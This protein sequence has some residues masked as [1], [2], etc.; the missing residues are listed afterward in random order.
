MSAKK[1]DVILVT[2]GQGFIGGYL[3]HVLDQNGFHNVISL[4]GFKKGLDLGDKD[5]IGWVFDE[6]KPDIVIHLACRHAGL[7][8]NL[9]NPAGIMYENINMTTGIMEEAC[10]NDCK[11][12]IFIGDILSYPE[13]C[14][15]PFKESD[16]WFGYPELARSGYALTKRFLTEMV[17]NYHLEGRIQTTSLIFPE[18]YGSNDLLDPRYGRI[19][20]T[21]ILNILHC[22]NNDIEEIEIE[23][24]PNTTR[25]LLY[26]ADAARAILLAVES[27]S[28][29]DIINIGS[30][31]ETSLESLLHMVQNY[32]DTNIKINWKQ[33]KMPEDKRRLL[34]TS[35]SKSILG[36]SPLCSVESG[37]KD[38][39]KWLSGR[40]TEFKEL[41]SL[42]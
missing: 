14:P 7:P 30:G 12:F 15:I 24:N 21:S 33:K 20:P 2:G 11:K 39:C 26:V 32:L 3:K 27:E 8:F 22:K 1:E 41:S 10:W 31:V 6:Y 16:L 34:D 5:N 4:P 40:E 28:D 29:G 13:N 35:K 9:Q 23:G 42:L 18:V 19:V 17:K 36:F 25:D 38:V 37:I